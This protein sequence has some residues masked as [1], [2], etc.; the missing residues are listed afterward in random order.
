MDNLRVVLFVSRNK[1]NR[2]IEGF[3]ERRVSFLTDKSY[4]E[5]VVEFQ[6]FVRKSNHKGEMSRFYISVNKRDGDKI[7]KG[8]MHYLIDHEEINVARLDRVV[9]SIA[10]KKENASEK[11]WLFDYDDE[12]EKVGLFLDDLDSVIPEGMN[13]GINKTPNGYA[14]ITD[15]G[16]DSRALMH[17]WSKVELKRDDLICA[18]WE[19]FDN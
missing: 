1:D 6:D 14:I 11:R 17:R 5:L 16:F 4:D 15:G 18:E 3:K 12:P 8:L 10:S 13:Y 9:S 19:V 2:Y 7:K